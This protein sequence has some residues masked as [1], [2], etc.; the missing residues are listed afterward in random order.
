VTG[1]A[2]LSTAKDLPPVLI[3]ITKAY[4]G[5]LGTIASPHLN[6]GLSAREAAQVE[7]PDRTLVEYPA[8]APY[9][10]ETARQLAWVGGSFCLFG[11]LGALVLQGW[12]G[13]F[14]KLGGLPVGPMMVTVGL[15][16]LC[17][18]LAIGV[19]A[20]VRIRR[21]G[22]APRVHKMTGVPGKLLAADLTPL[23]AI[24]RYAQYDDVESLILQLQA[25]RD[26]ADTLRGDGRDR[27][28]AALAVALTILNEYATTI[29]PGDALRTSAH[30]AVDAV[31][32]I[33]A[34]YARTQGAR[35]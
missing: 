21:Y 10:L 12:D 18:A 11:F 35:Q 30:N 7:N 26:L 9:K 34:Q 24:D 17:A 33:A 27:A 3:R 15:A 29:K 6:N 5:G 16:L 22:E 32:I 20:W 25:H 31:G 2:S 23:P 8:E 28:A 14:F 19:R 4:R 13:G 1:I